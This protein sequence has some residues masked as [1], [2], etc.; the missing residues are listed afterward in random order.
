M[1]LG[2]LCGDAVRHLGRSCGQIP[3]L[4]DDAADLLGDAHHAVRDSLAGVGHQLHAHDI[5]QGIQLAGEAVSLAAGLV[6]LLAHVLGRLAGFVRTLGA[7][8]QRV[9][10]LGIGL[11]EVGQLLLCIGELCIKI[12][13]ALFLV[14]V[15]DGGFLRFRGIFAESDLGYEQI[16][17]Q[18]LQALALGVML[19]R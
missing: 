6:L 19:L 10:R 7:V 18:L 2:R 3:G 13:N 8:L 12:R 16:A 11:L 9:G 1:Q 17:A 15:G 5:G 14:R 4:A